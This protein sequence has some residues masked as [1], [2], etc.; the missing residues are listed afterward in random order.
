MKMLVLS[1]GAAAVLAAVAA[2]ASA[3]WYEDFDSYE[4]GSGLHGQGGW[5]GW[6]GL[7]I[8]DGYITD[9]YAR[10]APNS[11]ES[12]LS[13]DMVHEFEGYTSGHCT[14]TAWQYIPD[15]FVGESYFIL[16]NT[17]GVG[18][19]NFSTQI[20]FD[21]LGYVESE[22]ENAQLALITGQWVELRVE[23]D[24]DADVQD[25]YYDGN[26]L[27]SKSWT[28][29]VSGGGAVNIGAVDIFA[30][31]A[32][33]VYWDDLDLFFEGEEPDQDGDGIPDGEDNCPY[34]YNPDQADCDD[35]GYGDVCTIAD[36]PGE[37][38][39]DDCNGNWIPDE[40]DIA[41]GSS[42]DDNS[43][44]IP[45]ECE[46]GFCQAEELRTLVPSGPGNDFGIATAIYD[47]LA[48]VGASSEGYG[49][50][51]I[52][53]FDGSEWIEEARIEAST[54]T[55]GN[56]GSAVAICEN[57]V[58][59]GACP[60]PYP[61][62]GGLLDTGSAYIFRFDGSSW[63]EEAK[64]VPAE[65]SGGDDVGSAVAINGDIAIVGAKWANGNAGAS[66]SAYVFHFDGSTWVEEAELAAPDGKYGDYFGYSLGMSDDTVIV[67]ARADYG[68]EPEQDAGAAYIFR[69]DGQDWEFD[70]KLVA[71]DAA[72]EDAFGVSVAVDGATALVGAHFSDDNGSNSGS[73]YLFCHD[74]SMWNPIG[75][76][77]PSDGAQ[78]DHFGTCVALDGDVILV[79]AP[80][81]DDTGSSDGSVYVYRTAGAG[82]TLQAKLFASDAGAHG[83][84]GY[85]KGLSVCDGRA[86]I[87]AVGSDST[88]AFHGLTDCQPN[89][90]LDICD[91]AEGS[92][93]D[94]NN[95]GIPDECEGE[96]CPADFDGDGD[97]DTADLLHL[98]G[99]WGTPDGD[100]DGDGDTDTADLLALLAAWG[101][102]PE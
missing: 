66:G 26:L 90:I 36:C 56:F 15:D 68:G 95:N 44:G 43:N 72:A 33:P 82:W 9:L 6:E 8:F 83:L 80:G 22:S 40:C 39:C 99:A 96:E 42:S 85:P 100:V 51:Y 49:A 20:R 18:T 3:N 91:I 94:A 65:C 17:Y 16:L 69:Y 1:F 84:L 73:A 10:S 4:T 5:Y 70:S 57:L 71:P 25:I 47:D 46:L 34:H 21:F 11:L 77:V 93:E 45:D 12:T 53:R 76:L 75:K 14:F 52:Y 32:S 98:L 19:H 86:I 62:R 28:E 38:W 79:S 41:D 58:I 35:D 54:P 64:V 74:G 24:L 89:D 81:D 78:D 101:E 13:T 27:S 50:A 63:I 92:S 2:S 87:G 67:G 30:N 23:I 60:D 37:S 102:C 31:G 88:Y 55:E 7:P 61:C 59:A 48:I 29:G 97:V